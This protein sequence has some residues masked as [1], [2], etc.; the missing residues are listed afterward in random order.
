MCLPS[1][2]SLA[3]LLAAKL[4][5]NQIILLC[6]KMRHLNVALLELIH[7][8]IQPILAKIIFNKF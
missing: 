3:D 8:V 6:Y 1:T 7:L 2:T 4:V 5:H